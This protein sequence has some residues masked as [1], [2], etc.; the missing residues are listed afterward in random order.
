MNLFQFLAVELNSG[1]K[2]ADFFFEL[3]ILIPLGE[4]A[5]LLDGGAFVSDVLNEANVF[6][7]DFSVHVLVHLDL[8][9][10]ILF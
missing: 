10:D 5:F 9:L 7:H 1:L 6:T 2:L 8:R 3:D 4:L